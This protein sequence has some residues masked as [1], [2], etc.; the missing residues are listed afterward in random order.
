MTSQPSSAHKRPRPPAFD[1]SN[2]D[3]DALIPVTLCR[4]QRRPRGTRSMRIP[5]V[6]TLVTLPDG[7]A[8]GLRPVARRKT[9]T[10]AS[11]P[12]IG[13]V[14]PV[15][16]PSEQQTGNDASAQ[17]PMDMSYD[18]T[19]DVAMTE[20]EGTITQKKNY[21]QWEV[22]T[23]KI[24]PALLPRYMQY[25]R[26]LQSSRSSKAIPE[27]PPVSCVCGGAARMLTVSCLRFDRTSLPALHEA[28]F[29]GRVAE[30]EGLT[31]FTCKCATAP[32]QLLERG[33]FEPM[34]MK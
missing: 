15:P 7:T 19:H 34:A 24:L 32:R 11:Q 23:K 21:R 17:E 16:S 2:A 1:T 14:V 28:L 4:P 10:T 20:I 31:I 18:R 22:W 29:D 9:L 12:S 27:V 26:E 13:V 3:A 30:M 5:R 8:L 33:L 25:L 6:R